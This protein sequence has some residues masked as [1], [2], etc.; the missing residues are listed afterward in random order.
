MCSITV[1]GFFFLVYIFPKEST[2]LPPASKQ[3]VLELLFWKIFFE[4]LKGLPH[5]L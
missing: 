4:L 5:G 2:T 3:L 1:V